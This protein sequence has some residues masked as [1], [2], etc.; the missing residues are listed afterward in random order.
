M[1][2]VDQPVECELEEET[3][4]PVEILPYCPYGY[5]FA[6]RCT[7]STL[8]LNVYYVDKPYFTCEDVF[9]VHSDNLWVRDNSH[10]VREHWYQV[11]S[12]VSVWAVIV[13]DTVMG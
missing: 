7:I 4:E 9:S 13:V 3:E 10:A 1:M 6:N 12:S 5:N 11:R 8:R 2:I